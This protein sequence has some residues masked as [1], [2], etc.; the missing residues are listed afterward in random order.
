MGHPQRVLTVDSGFQRDLVVFRGLLPRN[1]SILAGFRICDGETL[2]NSPTRGLHFGYVLSEEGRGHGRL[3]Q[4]QVC[5]QDRPSGLGFRELTGTKEADGVRSLPA[6]WL[7]GFY[8][9]IL[10]P[11]TTSLAALLRAKNG[12]ALVCSGQDKILNKIP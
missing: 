5:T 12:S 9:I 2:M 6:A 4:N 11:M 8:A 10:A 1:P 3:D 7:A